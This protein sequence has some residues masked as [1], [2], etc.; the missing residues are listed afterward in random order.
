MRRNTVWFMTDPSTST[1]ADVGTILPADRSSRQ[2]A[3]VLRCVRLN[4]LPESSRNTAS[5]AYGRSAG[6][7]EEADAFG[8]KLLVCRAAVVC[9]QHAAAKDAFGDQRFDRLAILA[10]NMGGMGAAIIIATSAWPLGATVSQ[11]ET[12]EF[13]VCAHLKAETVGIET[14]ALGPDRGT[15]TTTCESAL[16]TDTS[17]GCLRTRRANATLGRVHIITI[18]PGMTGS[19]KPP[20]SALDRQTDFDPP[21]SEERAERADAFEADHEADLGHGEVGGAEQTFRPLDATP[22]EVGRRAL[23]VRGREAPCEV[24][25]GVPRRAGNGRRGRAARHSRRS[26]RS[27]ARRSAGSVNSATGAHAKYRLRRCMRRASDLL[28]DDVVAVRVVHHSLQPPGSAGRRPLEVDAL[29]DERL[30][31]RLQ[32]GLRS[33]SPRRDPAA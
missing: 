18:Q 26:I 2:A 7:L 24:I 27:R 8:T 16:I 11:R 19:R 32:V 13:G 9:L 25:L 29:G 21:A 1:T 4:Q 3:G 23:T 14:E 30:V 31:I 17:R 10:E 22:R 5:M 15:Y 6:S 33:T 20:G 28:E 12:I